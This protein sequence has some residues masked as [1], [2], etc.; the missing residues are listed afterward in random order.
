MSPSVPCTSRV[1]LGPV[2]ITWRGKVTVTAPMGGLIRMRYFPIA[3]V[4]QMR[5]DHF[6]QLAWPPQQR[7]DSAR[8]QSRQEYL[9]RSQHDDAVSH[10]AP[11]LDV[12][13]VHLHVFFAVPLC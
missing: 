2:G 3:T 11:A 6:T 5:L 9:H 12:F 7:S 1:F 13:D 4:R 10:Q 8:E